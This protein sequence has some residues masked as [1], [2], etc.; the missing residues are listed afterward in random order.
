MSDMEKFDSSKTMDSVKDKI[1]AEFVHSLPDDVWTQMVETEIKRWTEVGRTSSYQGSTVIPS[2]FSKLVSGL[3]DTELTKRVE[4][5]FDSSEWKARWE[6]D[7]FKLGEKI[8]TF[9]EEKFDV[10][11]K[12]WIS[13]VVSDGISHLM[14]DL[15][16]AIRNPSSTY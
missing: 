9:I 2:P 10:L 1:K 16:S 15:A 7:E 14:Q 3:L 13:T 8:L 11:L 5:M 12:Q 6:N 4:E